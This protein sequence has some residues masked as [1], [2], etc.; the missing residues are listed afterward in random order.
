VVCQESLSTVL[1]N[2]LKKRIL[3]SVAA[4]IL[5]ACA[6]SAPRTTPPRP[7]SREAA[8]A[9][10]MES[11]RD[12]LPALTMFLREMPKGGDLHNHLSGAIYAESFIRWAAEDGL[13]LT[14]PTLSI[15]SPPCTSRDKEVSAWE[16]TRNSALYDR[17]IDAWSVRNWNPARKSGHDQFFESFE[18]FDAAGNRRLGDMLAEVA[19]R[20]GVQNIS[21][22][23]LMLGPDRGR[24]LRLSRKL[25]TITDFARMRERLLAAGLRDSLIKSRRELDAAEAKQ[26][27]LMNCAVPNRNRGCNV[28][29]RYLYQ[30]LRGLD[31][32]SVFAQILTG[33]EMARIDSRWVGLNLVMPEDAL[34]P[35]RDFQLHMRMINYLHSLYPEVR[36][37][38]HA[39]ELAEGLVPPDGLR[40]HIRESIARGKA[41]RIGH[42][43]AITHEDDSENLMRHMAAR[44]ILVEVALTSSDVIL[45]IKGKSHPLR[46]YLKYGVPVAL[47][48]D[49]EGVARSNLTLEFRKAVQ[50]QDLDYRTL[51]RMVRNS[52]SYSFAEDTT[53][54]RLSRELDEALARFESNERTVQR[55]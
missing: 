50:E 18:K 31:Q 27:Q 3:L 14:V 29:I 47:A 41:T 49:D 38:L 39:G 24:E 5:S 53:K 12:D 33:F 52:I 32:Q 55:H 8:T 20:S 35:M 37:T 7:V 45:G 51:K 11:I 23:E 34:V 44:H 54:P 40:F 21:Y 43:T 22:L 36:I 25:G 19:S 48:T 6:Q 1:S 28:T 17:V 16:I 10:Y 30:V 26:R 46:T 42:G 15:S 4:L 2:C 9:A 13:C